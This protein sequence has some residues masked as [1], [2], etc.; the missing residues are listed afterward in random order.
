MLLVTK[1]VSLSR[2]A[3]CSPVLLCSEIDLMQ[4]IGAKLRLIDPLQT[5][6]RRIG[7]DSMGFVRLN[8]SCQQKARS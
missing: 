4:P 3:S 7:A 5:P 1:P 6:V 8:G 2:V